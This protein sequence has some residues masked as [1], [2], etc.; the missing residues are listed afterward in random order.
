MSLKNI[1]LIITFL[2][3]NSIS[4][5][6]IEMQARYVILLDYHSGEILYEKDADEK[7]YPA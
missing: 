3:I 6:K 4:H 5:S 1:I 2:L 7:I